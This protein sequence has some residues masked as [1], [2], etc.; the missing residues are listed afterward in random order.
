MTGSVQTQFRDDLRAAGLS[1]ATT[2]K[3]IAMLQVMLAYGISIDLLNSELAD[4]TCAEC[5][6]TLTTF[7]HDVEPLPNGHWLALANTKMAVALHPDY[8][9]VSTNERTGKI[10]M[11]EKSSSDRVKRSTL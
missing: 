3:I 5:R 11:R 9:V 6:V 10:T 4:A 1:V 2:R 8:E 7:H